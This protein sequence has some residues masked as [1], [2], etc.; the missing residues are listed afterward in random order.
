MP[1]KNFKNVLGLLKLW[2][3]E[4]RVIR[5]PREV[6][7]YDTTLDLLHFR[8][9]AAGRR[10]LQKKAHELQRMRMRLIRHSKV[11]VQKLTALACTYFPIF[12]PLSALCSHSLWL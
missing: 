4:D 11:A 12:L 3:C 10:W 8:G 9:V 6:V 7:A 1:E 5:T 2:V